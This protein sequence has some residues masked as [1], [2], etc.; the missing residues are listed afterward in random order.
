[1]L[2]TLIVSGL[3][4]VVPLLQAPAVPQPVQGD[5]VI[6]S[7]RFASGETLPELRMHYRTYGT[8]RR[9]PQGVV[10]NTEIEG[11]TWFAVTGN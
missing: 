1:M 2:S 11:G 7:F 8:A 6:R 9:D 5:F 4:A 3:L 10:R